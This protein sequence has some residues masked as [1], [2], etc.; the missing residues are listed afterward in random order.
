[1]YF[2]LACGLKC[3]KCTAEG[4]GNCDSGSCD[5]GFYLDETF[6][7]RRMLHILWCS[8]LCLENFKKTFLI[9]FLACVT[10]SL[11]QENTRL[12]QGSG[13]MRILECSL[14]HS[15]KRYCSFILVRTEPILAVKQVNFWCLL[16]C[17]RVQTGP[18]R[19][20]RTKTLKSF[21]SLKLTFGFPYQVVIV[22]VFL[23]LFNTTFR[24]YLKKHCGNTVYVDW[25]WLVA[26]VVVWDHII[27]QNIPLF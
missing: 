14:V 25:R 23:T 15:C 1:M 20:T 24:L 16:S 7:C 21:F 12:L 5:T 8:L 6:K 2:V 4:Y 27:L 13:S 17:N 10:S 22:Y 11:N 19:N 18:Y 26:F 9:L 3:K